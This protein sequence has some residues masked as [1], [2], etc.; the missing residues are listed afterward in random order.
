MNWKVLA[1]PIALMPMAAFD[2]H[3]EDLP[4]VE[5]LP[6]HIIYMYTSHEVA[7]DPA[8]ALQQLYD[9]SR[10]WE[11]GR[12]LR[13]CMFGGNKT[14]ASL[15]KDVAGEWNNYS[16]V[17]LDFGN[18]PGGYNCLDRQLGYFQ[19]RIGFQDRGYW[20]VVGKDSETLID[21]LAPSMNLERFNRQ[22]SEGR[23]SSKEVVS[24]ADTYHKAVIRHEFGHALGLLH[25]H[26]NTKL[27]CYGEI[28]WNGKGNVYEYFGG[29][30]NNWGKDQVDRNLGFIGQTDPGFVAGVGDA[31]SI[32]MYQL[33][34]DIFK[35][36]KSK[37]AMAKNY[38]I[39]DLDKDI[40]AKIYPPVSDL[41]LSKDA[42][43]STAAIRPLASAVPVNKRDDLIERALVDLESDDTFS[44][45][46]ARVRLADLVS[47]ELPQNKVSDLV[48]SMEGGSYRYKIG[49]S[50]ALARSKDQIRLDSSDKEIIKSLSDSA[51]DEALKKTL[52]MIY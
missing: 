50:T 2:L 11:P 32:M 24:K 38:E 3:A 1:F 39:S 17:K 4:V 47:S 29:P 31:K 19:I 35:D 9:G 13:V 18:L 25:E 45:R 52:K 37:C 21:P 40:V 8:S 42:A 14:V 44:R 5:G 36:P 43:L 6:E 26:Q 46:D 28:K 41:V 48:K 7:G 23:Y 10:R 49:V 33:P 20:S 27:N 12:V 22:Y 15:V 51:S 34:A 16:S 30:P